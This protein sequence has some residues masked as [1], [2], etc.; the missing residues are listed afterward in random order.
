[1][2]SVP[3]GFRTSLDHYETILKKLS[4]VEI[5]KAPKSIVTYTHILTGEACYKKY[6]VLK[7][8]NEENV[9]HLYHYFKERL[10]ELEKATEEMHDFMH[11]YQVVLLEAK[12][13]NSLD[14]ED[15]SAVD[16]DLK[17]LKW[18]HDHGEKLTHLHVEEFRLGQR[19]A[20]QILIP[21][22]QKLITIKLLF[23]KI[24]CKVA[25]E[26]IEKLH[27]R[28]LEI[29]EYKNSADIMLIHKMRFS[30]FF[31]PK[32]AY[33][34]S[35]EEMKK[36]LDYLEAFE[37]AMT[38]DLKQERKIKATLFNTCGYEDHFMEDGYPKSA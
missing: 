22:Y 19:S 3:T 29:P 7:V 32:A 9:D 2:T 13:G 35:I 14:E 38:E 12:E 26:Q 33:L 17:N 23:N 1:M 10:E 37:K 21:L 5:T 25:N 15:Q 30:I 34:L 31:A 16:R 4:D 8:T 6:K 20:I 11:K 28:S 27:T 24:I 36:N 18:Y